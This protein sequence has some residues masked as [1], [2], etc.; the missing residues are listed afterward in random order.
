M[1][2]IIFP[3]FL[4]LM[5][6]FATG[7]AEG[8]TETTTTTTTTDTTVVTPAATKKP[9][10]TV[11]PS[12]A[13]VEEVDPYTATVKTSGSDLNVRDKANQG[14]TVLLKLANGSELTVIGV[15]GQWFKIKANGVTGFVPSKYV[16]EATTT[17]ADTGTDVA[18]TGDAYAAGAYGAY[19]AN[20]YGA[21]S[22]TAYGAYPSGA[23]GYGT[24]PQTA[25]YGIS[26]TTFNPEQYD[27]VVNAGDGGAAIMRTEPSEMAAQKATFYS[28]YA[29]KVLAEINGWCLVLDESY[30][31]AGYIPSV[32]LQ[33]TTG[34][35][36]AGVYDT[37]YDSTYGTTD[38]SAYDPMSAV[39]GSTGDQTNS[40]YG[41]TGGTTYDP[42]SAVYGTSGGTTY[43]PTNAAYGTTGGTTYDPT[44]AA[45][46]TTGGTT[47][48]P[49]NAAYGTTGGTT[50][51][52][53]N[54]A[55]TQ[56]NGTTYDPT[57]AAY[58][59]TNGTSYT[60]NSGTTYDPTNA[61]Y[62]QTNGTTYNQTNSTTYDSNYG[63]T[64]N[65]YYTTDD[66]GGDQG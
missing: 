51:D 26:V 7:M 20:A 57:N 17:Q 33:R 4:V 45:Y 63:T 49:T 62:T 66:D 32:L 35:A 14:A 25:G 22:G 21:Y 53:S 24:V 34:D 10:P 39:Y 38:T 61:A 15:T 9:N 11:P 46:G 16:S 23:A 2:K 65:Q 43:D 40:T 56:T 1:K 31:Q 36:S 19:P 55:Y 41:T 28:G 5:L 30:D 12:K 64:Y 44:N 42:M 18:G 27:A 3:V 48:D 50:Y 52:P 59:Q 13:A 47:Y 60:Q 8:T 29:F 58:T 54:T 6:L 37:G